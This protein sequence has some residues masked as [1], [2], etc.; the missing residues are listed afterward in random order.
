VIF[1]TSL[2]TSIYLWQ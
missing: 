1:I 2:I